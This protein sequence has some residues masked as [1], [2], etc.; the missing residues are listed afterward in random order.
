MRHFHNLRYAATAVLL[1][2]AVISN[3]AQYSNIEEAKEFINDRLSRSVIQKVGPDGLV[4]ISAPGSKFQFNLKQVNFNYNGGNGD[5]RVRVVCDNC[6]EEYEQK[7]LKEK[8]SRQS[9]LCD[10]EQEAYEVISAFRFMKKS[11]TGETK[12]GGNIDKPL[13][14]ISP[15]AGY[16]TVNEAIDFINGNLTRSVVMGIDDQGFMTINAPDDM[17]KVNM[18]S[19]EFGY[20]RSSDEP[21]VRIYGDFSLV[22]NPGKRNEEA[23]SRQSF[24]ASSRTKA[25][26]VIM[27]LYYLKSV[28]TG[29]D[30]SKVPGLNNV[31]SSKKSSYVNV[32]EAID[33]INDRLAY[34]IVLG[35]DKSGNVAINGPESIFRFNVDE[36]TISKTNRQS[37]R[38]DWFPFVI[39][40][41]YAPG[42]LVTCKKECIREFS[43]PSKFETLDEQV[44]QCGNSQEAK[45]VEKAFGYIR[46]FTGK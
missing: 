26:D 4:T 22:Q 21:K 7:E 46:T 5:D 19:A 23:I 42:I 2:C 1:F 32:A 33:Y 12:S 43:S 41:S 40:G 6:I 37:D 38:N 39:T 34:S 44:F 9:F 14:G 36:V 11:M 25:Y 3:F 30:V 15:V 45:E 29:S 16:K 18:K 27:A 20:N 31:S 35:V 8:L 17:F 24:E 13:T 10:S 28:Y